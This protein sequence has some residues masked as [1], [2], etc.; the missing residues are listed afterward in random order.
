MRVPSPLVIALCLLPSLAAAQTPVEQ[1]RPEVLG[2]VSVGNLWDD[3]SQLGLGL[4]GGGGIGYRWHE[5]VGVEGRVEWFSHQR[6]FLSGVR[7]DAEGARIL[8]QVAYYWSNGKA[9][10]FASGTA[11]VSRV[12]QTNESPIFEPGAGG[13][14]IRIGTDIH[15]SRVTDFVWGGSGGVRIKLTDRF[16]LRPEAGILVSVPHNFIDIRFGVTAAVSW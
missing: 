12:T 1:G 2:T 6:T 7:F 11:G 4:A 8:G 13:P 14:P 15:T 5:R 16:A 9:Q 3:E 10:P